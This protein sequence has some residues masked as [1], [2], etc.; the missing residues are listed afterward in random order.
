MITNKE[1]S[2]L[3]LEKCKGKDLYFNTVTEKDIENILNYYGRM[4]LYIIKR[5]GFITLPTYRN[6]FKTN[7]IRI[8]PIERR[9]V[10]KTL[11]RRWLSVRHIRQRQQQSRE[12]DQV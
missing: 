6:N 4:I 5:G 8:A 7:C 10:F 9:V 12:L 1:I 11:M 2:K 3:V